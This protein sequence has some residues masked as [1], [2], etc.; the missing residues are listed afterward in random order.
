MIGF[1]NLERHTYKRDDVVNLNLRRIRC[2]TLYSEP[3]WPKCR[4]AVRMNHK[5]TV[6]EDLL[7][8][9]SYQP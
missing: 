8:K 5:L 7:Q 1:A 6:E 4:T 3:V 9:K 2:Y